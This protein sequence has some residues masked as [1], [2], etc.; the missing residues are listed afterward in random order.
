MR[1]NQHVAVEQKVQRL[2]WAPGALG[3]MCGQEVWK[4]P[5]LVL[6]PFR[7]SRGMEPESLP[8]QVTSLWPNAVGR[9]SPKNTDI[10]ER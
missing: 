9:N 10:Q 3:S 4:N 7:P 2:L 8:G 6:P 5:L 1:E